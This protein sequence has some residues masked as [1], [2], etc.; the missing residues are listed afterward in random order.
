MFLRKYRDCHRKRDI[1]FFIDLIP[2]AAPVSKIPYIIST[3][4]LKELQQ[5]IGRIVE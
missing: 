3:P 4:N 1:D 2:G 5:A